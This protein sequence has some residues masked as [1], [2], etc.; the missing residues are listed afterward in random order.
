MAKEYTPD[1]LAGMDL[2]SG[3]MGPKVRAACRFV[4]A[5]GKAAVIGALSEAENVLAGQSGTR[6]TP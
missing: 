6:I 4:E 2:D 5:T 3:S 1:E